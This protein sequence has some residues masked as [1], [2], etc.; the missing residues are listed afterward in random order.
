[1]AIRSIDARVLVD[2]AVNATQDLHASA[3]SAGPMLAP[4]ELAS[5]K[6]LALFDWAAARDF[7]DV[8][9]LAHRFGKDVLLTRATRSPL[10]STP[11]CSPNVRY[12]RP[13][14]RRRDPGAVWNR[15]YPSS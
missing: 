14:H 1:M 9:V 5:H 8:Y 12:P 4:E 6:Q 2:L 15:C 13:V 10:A 7:A 3:T 11:A